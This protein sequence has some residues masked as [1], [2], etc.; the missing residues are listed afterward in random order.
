M[1][2]KDQSAWD[3]YQ[4]NNNKDPMGRRIMEYAE[5][6]ANRMEL[7]MKSGRKLEECA[8][9]TSCEADYDGITGFMHGAAVQTLFHC[10]EYGKQLKAWE[11]DSR[12]V[13]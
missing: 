12:K 5:E 4:A 7:E 6:W 11:F 13:K 1:I 9:G 10:W 8:Y 3:K 2:I